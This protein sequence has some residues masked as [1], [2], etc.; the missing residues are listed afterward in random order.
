MISSESLRLIAQAGSGPVLIDNSGQ[1]YQVDSL[2]DDAS[3]PSL[4]VGEVT[5]A[6]KRVETGTV[7]Q[8][9]NRDALWAVEGFL[10]DRNVI[11]SLP[12]DVDS[13]E[14]LIDAVGESGFEW[15]VVIPMASEPRPD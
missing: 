7:V 8:Y 4:V 10:L 5:E 3:V 12:D 15:H 9:L 2:P 14:R 1:P 11:D 13:S 6:V